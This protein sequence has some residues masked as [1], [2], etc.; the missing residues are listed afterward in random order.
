MLRTVIV[1]GVIKKGSS[2]CQYQ[3]SEYNSITNSCYPCC[4]RATLC[5]NPKHLE[6]PS[7]RLRTDAVTPPADVTMLH[8]EIHPEHYD[9]IVSGTGLPESYLAG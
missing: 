1:P 5:Q 2:P 6:S 7:C 9:L 3:G 4:H 8:D